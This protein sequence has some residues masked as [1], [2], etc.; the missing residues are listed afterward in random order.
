MVKESF[1]CV[2]SCEGMPAT[3]M[4]RIVMKN[5]EILMA[6]RD[7]HFR[8]ASMKTISLAGQ[9]YIEASHAIILGIRKLEPLGD[10]PNKTFHQIENDVDSFSVAS[11]DLE[12][13]FPFSCPK[14]KANPGVLTNERP[15]SGCTEFLS[16]T[17]FW[18]A[19]YPQ[20]LSL[21][22]LIVTGF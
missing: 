7:E 16:S 15:E 14:R 19:T 11:V 4:K 20:L 8:Q 21:R 12:L 18:V 13:E 3:Y 1:Q 22:D 2:C 9:R 5:I 17:C 6:A 10:R